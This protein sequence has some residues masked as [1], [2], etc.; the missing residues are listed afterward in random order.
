MLSATLL[1]I[2]FY[3]FLWYCCGLCQRLKLCPLFLP[4]RTLLVTHWTMCI[5]SLWTVFFYRVIPNRQHQRQRHALSVASQIHGPSYHKKGNISNRSFLVHFGLSNLFR[6]ILVHFGQSNLFRSILVHSICFIHFGSISSSS[7]HS[8]PIQ[9]IWSTYVQFCIFSQFC[10][11]RSNLIH[12]SS[13]RSI[14]SN[15]VYLLKNG[16]RQVLIESTINY[17]SNINCNYRISF[18]YYQGCQDRDST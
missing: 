13:L 5:F 1:F 17:L 8:G 18:G 15:S 4:L 2:K 11:L 6:S 3:V 12:F 16:K 7:V 14:W 10:P 9:S